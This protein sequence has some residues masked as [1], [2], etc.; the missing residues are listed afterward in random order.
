MARS[1]WAQV[2]TVQVAAD[3][4]QLFDLLSD[5]PEYPTWLPRSESYEATTD[6]EPYP[7]RLGTRYHD[8]KPG[9]PGKDWWGEVTG[10]QPPGSLDFHHV[11]HVRQ[12]RAQVDVRIHYSFERNDNDGNATTRVER[13]LLLDVTMPRALLPLRAAIIRQFDRENLRTMAAVRAY[14]DA[15]AS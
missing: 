1:R 4:R 8:G 6:V 9:E 2:Y 14:A 7:V 11:I 5:L 3:P 10:F 13:W 12:L 15:H